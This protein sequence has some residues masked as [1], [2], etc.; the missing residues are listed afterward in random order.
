LNWEITCPSVIQQIKKED[1]VSAGT[2]YK[3]MVTNNASGPQQGICNPRN[4]KQVKN[5]QRI[6]RAERRI[7][8]DEIYNVVEI[9]N[10]LEPFV[11]YY[12]VHPDMIC[13][14]GIKELFD[15]FSRVL[16]VDPDSSVICGYDTTF[17]LG[18]FYVSALSFRHILFEGNPIIPFGFVIHERKFQ[19]VHET[20][21]S[22]IKKLVPNLKKDCFKIAIVVDKETGI[23]NAISERL[24][25]WQILH[26]WNHIKQDLKFWLRKHG[27]KQDDICIYIN[28]IKQLLQSECVEEFNELC[29]TLS[30]KWSR[31][32][33]HHFE[34]NLKDDIVKYS[35]KWVLQDCGTY[36]PYSGVTNNASESLNTVLK[37][38]LEWKEVPLD[39][40]V[41]SLYLLQNFY[42]LEIQRGLASI[43]NYNLKKKFSNAEISSDEIIKPTFVCHPDEIVKNVKANVEQITGNMSESNDNLISSVAI[44]NASSSPIHDIPLNKD[45]PKD[46]Y[47]SQLALAKLI[48]SSGNIQHVPEM[49]TF[50]VKGS[51]EKNYCVSLH[52]KEMCQ[53]PSTGLCYHIIA[54]QMSIGIEPTDSKRNYNMSQLRRNS[55]K[56]IDK[57][58]G[59]KI[60]RT[61]DIVDTSQIEPAPDSFMLSEL[62]DMSPKIASTPTIMQNE[63]CETPKSILKVKCAENGSYKKSK[64]SLKFADENQEIDDK[65]ETFQSIDGVEFFNPFDDYL[66][67]L[68]NTNMSIGKANELSPSLDCPAAKK[69][70]VVNKTPKQNIKA[71]KVVNKTPEQ[72]IKAQKVVNKT[73]E[74]NIKAK[75]VKE[76]SPSL[77]CPAAKKI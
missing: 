46:K 36:D 29:E 51:G 63:Q 41:L 52:P 47:S 18:D 26:C 3:K 13:I 37:R 28:D 48:I 24:P 23:S 70:K 64:K 50:V 72:N 44:D 6:V 30:T 73:P 75:E 9:A 65:N 58:S 67:D 12:K 42:S 1:S 16:E 56:R 40:I 21:F 8:H 4:L 11:H 49:K 59:R 38:L 25:G 76:L 32:F 43:G 35:A 20:F 5:A 19:E 71:Q 15:E 33:L 14:L 7:S 10:H 27:G 68:S 22:H 60:P 54:A 57:K 61:N 77:D 69:I 2:L 31:A 17:Q 74:Q 66:P 53:C 62:H 45:E 39:K 34:D 55:R